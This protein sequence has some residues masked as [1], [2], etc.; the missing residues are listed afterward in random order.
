MLSVDLNKTNII[1]VI[2]K[3]MHDVSDLCKLILS[4]QLNILQSVVWT[5]I[6]QGQRALTLKE[7]GKMFDL[8]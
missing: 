1:L 8:T 2:V 4:G 3:K 5:V 7:D 6:G